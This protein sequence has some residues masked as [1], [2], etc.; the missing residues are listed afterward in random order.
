MNNQKKLSFYAAIFVIAGLVM[1]M[2]ILHSRIFSVTS[3]YH[4][5]F[6]VISV[7]MFGLTLGALKIHRGDEKEQRKNYSKI[8]YLASL[9]CGMFLL[10]ALF[11]Q[12][13]MPMVFNHPLV[14]VFSLPFMAAATSMPYYFAGIAISVSL[15]RSPYSIGKIYGIDLLGAAA[16]CLFALLIMKTIDTPSAIVIL[17][18][19]AAL[20]AYLYARSS[21]SALYTKPVIILACISILIATINIALPKPF[22]YPLW[23]KGV[24]V[25]S[26]NIAYEKWNTI[27]RVTVYHEWR[28]T[29][30]LWGPSPHLPKNATS[31]YKFLTIDGD[32][33][34]PITSFNPE[35]MSSHKY[36]EYDVVNMA[37]ALPNMEDA[38]IIGVGGGRDLL[39]AKYF[40]AKTAVAIDVNP[41]QIDLLKN[42]P[43]FSNYANLNKLPGVELINSEARSWFRQNNRKFDIIQ[44]SLIDTWAA[45]GAGAFALSENG[46]YT[47]EAW[48]IFLNDLSENGVFTVSRWYQEGATNETA[49]LLSL[50]M[51]SLFAQ[52]ISDTQEHI[53][54]T[55]S[56]NI[57]TLILSKNP[58]TDQQLDALHN[59]ADKMSFRVLASPRIKSAEGIL[60]NFLRIKDIN[61]LNDFADSLP[62]YDLSPPT[63]MK[64]F[65]FNQTR[66]TNP[67][68]IIKLATSKKVGAFFG[69]AKATMNLFIII[70]FSAVMVAAVIIWPLRST[71]KNMPPALAYNGTFYFLMI[72]FGFMLTEISLLQALGIFL[73][74]PI[75]GL[76]IVL[77]SLILSAGLGSLIS[78]KLPL[79]NKSWQIG[80][81]ITTCIYTIFLSFAL[82]EAFINFAEV[83]LP[84]RASISVLL[85]IPCGMLLGYGFP[86]GLTLIEKLDSKSTVWFWGINGAAGV[87]AST[88]A[89]A[90]N[91]ILGL[92]K[93][94]IIGGTC[95]L[96]LMIPM[97]SLYG[98]KISAP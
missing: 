82:K 13:F 84:L 45:T 63:D 73:G 10:F 61:A 47:T 55:G 27:S 65:F 83:S 39:S 15:T 76:S 85:I 64:P 51:S 30:H 67:I 98:K 21:D 38:A 71:V 6:L 57:A 75:Y 42:H 88:I 48:D 72:G 18:S 24:S 95:Y 36:L 80:W 90:L 41:V 86:T 26:E 12:L 78:D 87:F 54:L 9:N 4:L 62:D 16:G 32:A 96:L 66:M 17:S 89:I 58:F 3:W 34:T 22:I 93:T 81:C 70:I 19:A 77:F 40:G 46:L 31:A 37:Y 29:P 28:G 1:A 53:F 74:H 91:I 25:S 5:S 60:G 11:V 97:L 33:G 68:K 2:Q 56:G 94:L 52:G 50:A 20:G 14:T 8:A 23:V 7:A 79:K 35:D 44:M 49:R 92:D 43:E 59:R 69:H